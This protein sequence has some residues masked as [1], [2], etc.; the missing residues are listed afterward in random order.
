MESA[1]EQSVKKIVVYYSLEGNTKFIAEAIAETVDA[2][3]LQ[4]RPKDELK[5][6]G[7]MRILRGVAQVIAKKK[8]ELHPFD[9][10]CEEYDLL[11][12]GTP[13]WAGGYA[14]PLATFFS[15]VNLT[16]KKVALFCTYGRNEGNALKNMGKVLEGNDILGEIGFKMPL[17]YDKDAAADEVKSW[18]QEIISDLEK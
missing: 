2:D 8:P 6:R 3:V 18:A 16:G 4:L 10:K 9:K 14:A 13:V 7:I 5:P 1:L 11:F 12:I 15:T 17:K